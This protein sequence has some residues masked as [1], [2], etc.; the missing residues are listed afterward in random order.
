M[1]KQLRRTVR[2]F[3]KKEQPDT[4]LQA[5]LMIDE[6]FG[7]YDPDPDMLVEELDAHFDDASNDPGNGKP[8]RSRAA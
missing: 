6:W 1:T 4:P 3:L 8:E 5:T 7:R 2:K